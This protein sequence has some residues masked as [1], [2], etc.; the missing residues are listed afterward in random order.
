MEHIQTS[1]GKI[2]PKDS[3]TSKVVS[4]EAHCDK[5]F[6]AYAVFVRNIPFIDKPIKT[7]SCPECEKEDTL[8]TATKERQASNFQTQARIN[9][10]LD[11]AMIAPR[12]KE[13][14]FENYKPEN[15]GQKKVLEVCD[16]FLN[17]W[18]GSMGLIFIGGPGTGKNHLASALIKKFVMEDKGTALMTE[19]IKVI[20]AIKESWRSSDKTETQV[21]RHFMEPDLLVVDEVGV[22]FGTETERMFLTEIINDRYNYMKPTILIGNLTLDEMKLAIGERALERFKEGGKVVAFNWSSHRGR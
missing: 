14:T 6:I 9:S 3:K 18:K 15:D 22:Q 8:N 2:T 7:G 12:F 10:R 21:M 5:H 1:P 4:Y 16:W 13:K 20:R 19:A 11:N 17:N